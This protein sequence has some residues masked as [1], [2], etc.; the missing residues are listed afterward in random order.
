MPVSDA[1]N[2]G[3]PFVSNK[4]KR[5]DG[6]G[7]LEK[8][9]GACMDLDFVSLFRADVPWDPD[10]EMHGVTPCGVQDGTGKR[11]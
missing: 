1:F 5:N 10:N 2:I 11:V 9:Q 3:G 7:G 4:V 8:R 6:L